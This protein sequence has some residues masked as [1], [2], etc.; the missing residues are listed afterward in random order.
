MQ[1]CENLGRNDTGS[2]CGVFVL[3]T[4]EDTSCS[5]KVLQ[6]QQPYV[7]R[8]PYTGTLRQMLII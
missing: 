6:E 2:E 7:Y 5:H 4:G 3:L 8:L 1:A